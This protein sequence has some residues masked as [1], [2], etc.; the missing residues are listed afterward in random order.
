MIMIGLR[1][2]T[3]SPKIAQSALR[4]AH[5]DDYRPLIVFVGSCAG[6]RQLRLLALGTALY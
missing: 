5:T 2:A 1:R 3:K 4:D 6:I